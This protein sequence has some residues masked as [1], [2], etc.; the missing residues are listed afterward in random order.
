MSKLIVVI[1]GRKTSGKD[2][3]AN[4]LAASLFNIR[5]DPT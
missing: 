4:M 1:S 3:Y 2:T 5:N